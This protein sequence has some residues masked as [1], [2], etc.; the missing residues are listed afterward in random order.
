MA[1]LRLNRFKTGVNELF[2][3]HAALV[4]AIGDAS[5]WSPL[6]PSPRRS[7]TWPLTPGSAPVPG[8]AMTPVPEIAGAGPTSEEWLD[9]TGGTAP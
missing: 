7:P 5:A 2:A 9:P 1:A 8:P 3:E 4:A 6:R